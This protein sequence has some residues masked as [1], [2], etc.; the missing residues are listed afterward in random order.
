MD[1]PEAGAQNVVWRFFG[2]P[3]VGIIG[4][5]ASVIGVAL[6]IFFYVGSIREPRLTY[7]VHP[8]NQALQF[9]FT[10]PKYVDLSAGSSVLDNI[11]AKT[12]CC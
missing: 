3:I 2:K 12:I 8:V 1:I 10:T 7:Y 6:A 5:I 9:G 4:S 11:T